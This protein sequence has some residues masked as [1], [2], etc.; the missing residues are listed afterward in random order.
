MAVL[1]S[2]EPAG[3]GVTIAPPPYKHKPPETLA[4]AYKK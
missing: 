3:E 1:Q 4:Y 2:G